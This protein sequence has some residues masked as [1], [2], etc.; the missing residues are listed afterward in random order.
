MTTMVPECTRAVSPSQV[1]HRI[2]HIVMTKLIKLTSNEG[3][4]FASS[5]IGTY[6][7]SIFVLPT[8]Q[9]KIKNKNKK[10]MSAVFFRQIP[11]WNHIFT[12]TII[13]YIFDCI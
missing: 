11:F 4:R 2:S 12:R 5:P 3:S 8:Y 1:P 7:S 6:H 10:I 9:F 13:F